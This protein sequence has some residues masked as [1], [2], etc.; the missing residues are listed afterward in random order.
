MMPIPLTILLNAALLV[1]GGKALERM[2]ALGK[3]V[4]DAKKGEVDANEAKEKLT[5]SGYPAP[6]ADA[7]IDGLKEVAEK[8]KEPA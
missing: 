3:L 7:L 1:G 2:A 4:E 5:S 8:V 6:Q